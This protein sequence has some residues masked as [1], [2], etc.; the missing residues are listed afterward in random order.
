MNGNKFSNQF[1]TCE[2]TGLK[3]HLPAQKLFWVNAVSA[4]VFLLVGAI[5]A[6]MVALTRGFPSAHIITDSMFYQF[7]TAHGTNMLVFW[8]VFFEMAGLIFGATAI[9]G[10]RFPAIKLAWF[11]WIIM[12]IGAIMVNYS[13]FWE[14]TDVMFTA[15]PP[16]AAKSPFFYLGIVLFAVGALIYCFQF[17]IA[18]V[19]AKKEGWHEGSL[20]LFTFALVT[21]AIIAIFTL[22]MGAITFVPA[23]LFSLKDWGLDLGINID[24]AVFR[25][26]FWGFGHS[27]QQINLAAMVGIWYLLGTLTV[28]AQPV[29]EKLSRWAFFLYI[30][31]I[32]LGSIHHLLVDPAL[33]STYKIFNTTYL[34]YAAVIGSLIHAVS[35]PA[36][37]E[38][39]QRKKGYTKGLFQWLRKAPWSDPGFS[40]L[41]ISLVMF[42]FIGGVTGVVMSVEQLNILHHNNLRVPGHFHATVVAGTSLAFMVVAYKLI[43]LALQRKIVSEKMAKIQPYVFGIGILM[44]I[45]GMTFAGIMGVPR[46]SWDIN[47]LGANIFSSGAY[48]MLVLVGIGGVVAFIG[49]LMFIVNAVLSV[50]FGKKIPSKIEIHNPPYETASAKAVT[51]ES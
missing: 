19:I 6:I 27:A 30:I 35:I 17:L 45:V 41:A 3:V 24:P 43:P 7:L 33:K 32:N 26:T 38:V 44:V 12:I 40:G 5:M 36:A 10:S 11:N 48:S 51:A 34:M 25:L 29:N 21:A 22:L 1:R 42:G 16:L 49:L 20:P 15:Y 28:G 14:G 8:I 39:A 47:S 4:V 2:A 13:I 9:L 31:A 23:L 37:I 18:L 46:R 50:F